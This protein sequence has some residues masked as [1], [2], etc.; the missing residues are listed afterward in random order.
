MS[1]DMP[2]DHRSRESAFARLLAEALDSQPRPGENAKLSLCADA[3]ILAAYA[4]HGLADE[5]MAHWERH[6]ADCDRC[7][8]IIAALVASGQSLTQGEVER[9]G[10]LAAT[11]LAREP[12][13]QK[14]G[15][16]WMTIWRRPVFWRWLVPVAGLASA[17]LWFALRQAPQRG[18][19]SAEK[20]AV[21]A[22]TPQSETAQG[23]PAASSV[24]PEET[25]VAQAKL[26]PPAAAPSGAIFRDKEMEQRNDSAN[27][28]QEPARKQDAPRSAPQALGVS[29]ANRAMQALKTPED[30]A[31]DKKAPSAETTD[32]RTND[33]LTTVTAGAGGSA[34]PP[35][36][37]A[38]EGMQ[39]SSLDSGVTESSRNQV[40]SLAKAGPSE[41]SFASPE[42]RV[43][44]RLRSGGLIEHSTDQGRT[45]K[46]QASGVKDDLLAGAAPSENVAWAV[47][48]AGIILRTEDG[49]NWRRVPPPDSLQTGASP[50]AP[51]DWIGVE[52]RDALHVTITSR[53][54]RSFVTENGGRNWVSK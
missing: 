32:Q 29:E 14:T 26:P 41:V 46:P 13:F 40:K 50:T 7:Q 35:S 23:V 15:R 28:R 19:L 54:G 37:R 18:T 51:L 30:T 6:F 17:T 8:K 48:R 27:A 1:A 39:S 31:K 22:G 21:T 10:S 42:R 38:G 33:E 9:S 44:W 16:L 47:G 52:A 11:S 12:F 36:A 5:E 24:K 3:E 2:K 43:L 49:E 25:Q 4:E 45:W 53:G 20:I 34:A